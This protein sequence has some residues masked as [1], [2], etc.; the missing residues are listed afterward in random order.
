MATGHYAR[1]NRSRD[2]AGGPVLFRG[3]DPAKDQSYFLYGLSASQLDYCC[4]PLGSMTKSE[5]R[6]LVRDLNLPNAQAKESQDVCFVPSGF[7]A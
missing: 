4:F 7:I 3:A 6:T 1:R 5:V 2:G